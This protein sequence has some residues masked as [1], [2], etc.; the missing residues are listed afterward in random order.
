MV[1]Y[2]KKELYRLENEDHVIYRI[3]NTKNNKVYIGQTIL[4]FNKR[5]RGK[6]GEVGIQRVYSHYNQPSNRKN[7]HL[8]NSMSLYGL[9]VFKVDILKSGLTIEEL[10]YWEEFYIALYNSTDNRYG[11]NYKKGGNNHEVVQDYKDLKQN[12]FDKL[13]DEQHIKFMDKMLTRLEELKVNTRNII[14]EIKNKKIVVIDVRDKSRCWVYQNVIQASQIHTGNLRPDIIFTIAKQNSKDTIFDT[15]PKKAQTQRQFY[16]EEDIDVTK[17]YVVNA[18]KKQGQ[19]TR[20]DYLPE[21]KKPK[22]PKKPR[23][24]QT[25]EQ[26]KQKQRE[27]EKHY[28]QAHPHIKKCELCGKQIHARQYCADCKAKRDHEKQKQKAIQQ[29]KQIKK[30]PICGKEHWRTNSE[31]CGSSLCLK[32]F[33]E[34]KS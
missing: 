9:D 25:P 19:V 34:K 29:G 21:Y 26:K 8:V 18:F 33:K 23:Q 22:K 12:L 30:C 11:Y 28:R 27:R 14:E 4:T 20:I 31:T 1:K 16:F 6:N 2:T 24:L 13:K 7:K 32:R 5:Y 10:N 15:F 17:L 3:I